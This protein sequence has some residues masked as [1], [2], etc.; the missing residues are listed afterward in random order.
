[1]LQWAPEKDAGFSPYFLAEGLGMMVQLPRERFEVDDATFEAMVDFY[2]DLRA[3]LI[4][5]TVEDS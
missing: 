4:R 1:M 2:A 3:E 5:R